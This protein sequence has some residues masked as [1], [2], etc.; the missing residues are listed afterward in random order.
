MNNNLKSVNQLI[1]LNKNIRS[2][3]NIYSACFP[4][5]LSPDIKM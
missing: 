4:S 5:L 1:L 2:P 3:R